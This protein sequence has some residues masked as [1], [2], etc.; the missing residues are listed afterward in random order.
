MRMEEIAWWGQWQEHQWCPFVQGF[1]VS[2]VRSQ[3]PRGFKS[4]GL[5]VS[6]C[7]SCVRFIGEPHF[8]CGSSEYCPHVFPL[9]S[10]ACW[11]ALVF[12]WWEAAEPAGGH[13]S[14]VALLA[15]RLESWLRQLWCSAMRSTKRGEESC[16]SRMVMQTWGPGVGLPLPCH[17]CIIYPVV[18]ASQCLQSGVLSKSPWYCSS[19]GV[20]ISHLSYGN[21]LLMGISTSSL[22][23]HPSSILHMWADES[24]YLTALPLSLIAFKNKTKK[25]TF[26][27]SQPVM[28]W[29]ETSAWISRFTSPL[30]PPAFQLR[31]YIPSYFSSL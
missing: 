2:R 5:R 8:R 30:K 12:G 21:G 17:P 11:H 9:V 18:S 25:K 28:E 4:S 13:G 15:G 22:C 3:K 14:S 19:S 23:P 26:K 29:I 6:L 27:N 24:F 20:L 31:T 7:R 16:S 1:S 10:H